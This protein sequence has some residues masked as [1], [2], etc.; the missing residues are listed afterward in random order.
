MIVQ[1]VLVLDRSSI[2]C[3]CCIKRRG[4]DRRAKYFARYLIW[5]VRST[6]SSGDARAIRCRILP[7]LFN[8]GVIILREGRRN[9]G[10]YSSYNRI[11]IKPEMFI[12]CSRRRRCRVVLRH[13]RLIRNISCAPVA[14]GN[15][16]TLET[17]STHLIHSLPKLG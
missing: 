12:V 6:P 13:R 5:G 10:R 16:K 9:R 7:A 17:D 2:N 11:F 4:D 8:Y 14:H 15:C 1:H 3:E